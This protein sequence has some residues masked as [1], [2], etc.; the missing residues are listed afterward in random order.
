MRLRV[1]Q[2]WALVGQR[3]FGALNIQCA[4]DPGAQPFLLRLHFLLQN[5]HGIFAHVNLRAI[6]EELGKRDPHIHR[7]AIGD[8]LE[9]VL[10]L[11]DV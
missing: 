7:H 1:D 3:H 9:L 11:L 6:Q 10:L 5:P 2:L 4:D 8:F